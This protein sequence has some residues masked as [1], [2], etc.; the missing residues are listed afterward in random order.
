M[1]ALIDRGC[2]IVEVSDTGRMARGF[3]LYREMFDLQF[4]WDVLQMFPG[5]PALIDV[6]SGQLAFVRDLGRADKVRQTRVV[7]RRPE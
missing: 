4:G 3:E 5:D 6:L 2:E 1:Q 7:A